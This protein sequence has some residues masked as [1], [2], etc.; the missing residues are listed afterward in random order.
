MNIDKFL[1]HVEFFGQGISMKLVCSVNGQEY[2]TDGLCL[3][4]MK[5]K[6][7][8]HLDFEHDVELHEGDTFD[9]M[10]VQIEQPLFL[11]EYKHIVTPLL[12]YLEKAPQYGGYVQYVPMG[13]GEGKL[14]VDGECPVQAMVHAMRVFLNMKENPS[15]AFMFYLFSKKEVD[16]DAAFLLSQRMRI[17][18]KDNIRTSM[19]N[20]NHSSVYPIPKDKLEFKE[21]VS[22]WKSRVPSG[23]TYE[24]AGYIGIC[25]YAFEHRV[26]EILRGPQTYDSLLEYLN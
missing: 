5:G 12:S 1:K 11:N 2:V 8:T 3:S 26:P 20:D 16:L 15:A 17:Q 18:T 14:I 22:E 19:S 13:G 4:P 7:E 24:E 6:L 9:Y 10:G 25:K 21:I 23:P